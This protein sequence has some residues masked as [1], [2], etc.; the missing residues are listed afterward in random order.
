M[1]VLII[2]ACLASAPLACVHERIGPPMPLMSC[3]TA[4][5]PAAAQWAGNHPGYEVR[6]IRCEADLLADHT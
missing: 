2:T 5:Q 3:L 1:N 4:T 6:M